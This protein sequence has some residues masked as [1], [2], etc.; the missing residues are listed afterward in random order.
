MESL[1]NIQRKMVHA[2][3]TQKYAIKLKLVTNDDSDRLILEK[4]NFD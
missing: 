4:R 3:M 1:K 2:T